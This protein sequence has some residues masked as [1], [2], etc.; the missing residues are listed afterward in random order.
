MTNPMT[1][2]EAASDAARLTYS[3]MNMRDVKEAGILLQYQRNHRPVD[4]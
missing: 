2:L 1:A 3:S 4:I